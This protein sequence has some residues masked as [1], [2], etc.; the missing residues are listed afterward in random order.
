MEIEIFENKVSLNEELRRAEIAEEKTFEAK[1]IAGK[2]NKITIPFQQ[3][4]QVTFDNSGNIVD[5]K[6]QNKDTEKIPLSPVIDEALKLDYPIC[7]ES[8][9][10]IS[11]L[12]ELSHDKKRLKAGE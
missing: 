5:L 7:F 3:V 1:K 12:I 4:D 6:I 8:L 2:N 10:V 11:D 9:N